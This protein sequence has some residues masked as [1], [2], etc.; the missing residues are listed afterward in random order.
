M[1][2]SKNSI[3]LKDLLLENNIEKDYLTKKTRNIVG[4]LYNDILNA[5]HYL[6]W[7]KKR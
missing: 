5:F 3:I 7:L 4:I 2:L 1:R 6:N